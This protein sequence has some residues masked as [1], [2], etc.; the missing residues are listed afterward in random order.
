MEWN[1]PNPEATLLVLFLFICLF[2]YYL[3]T[4]IFM[5]PPS[6]GGGGYCGF[7]VFRCPDVVCQ[8]RHFFAS[9]DYLT[10]FD[11]IWGK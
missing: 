7:T 4:G 9:H 10:D 2:I 6:M 8:H 11:E 3:F 1:G 5:P